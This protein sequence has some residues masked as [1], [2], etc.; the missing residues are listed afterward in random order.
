[1]VMVQCP[2]PSVAKFCQRRYSS[3]MRTMNISLPAPLKSFV[4]EQVTDR[5]YGSRSAYIRDLIRH[6]RDRQHLR[7]LLLAGRESAPAVTADAAY[8]QALRAGVRGSAEA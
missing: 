6:D 7:T 4:D 8:F 1:M 5:G 2:A 3:T